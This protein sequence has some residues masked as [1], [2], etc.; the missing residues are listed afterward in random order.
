VVLKFTINLYCLTGEPISDEDLK[1][2]L[3]YAEKLPTISLTEAKKRRQDQK[4][5]L[6]R[7]IR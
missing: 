3:E 6:Q 5:K 4:K 7:L 1:K 2:W